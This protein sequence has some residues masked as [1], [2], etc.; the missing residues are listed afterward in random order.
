MRTKE[1]FYWIEER[2][3]IYE[4][5]K[6]GKPKPWTKDPILQQYRFCNV[7]RELDTV[8]QWIAK[9]WRTPHKT[10]RHLW[11]AMVV[12][13]LLN[14]PPTLSLVKFPVPWSAKRFVE[15]TKVA[16]AT[17]YRIFSGAYIV[18]TN[19]KAVEKIPYLV[20]Y[21]L[22]PLWK[23]RENIAAVIHNETLGTVPPPTLGLVHKVLMNYDGLGSFMAA[24]VIAD[25]KY[26]KPLVNAVDWH[27]W[28]ASGP[29]SRRGLNR[30][31]GSAPNTP[32]NEARWWAH[33]NMLHKE[34]RLLIVKKGMPDLHAQDLQ[35]CLCEFDKY[36]RTRLGEGRP[37]STY[38]GI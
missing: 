4:A 31:F 30:V 23:A 7:Y 17:N 28:A 8:T 3:K 11:F 14:W 19:G 27:T 32:W 15:L 2:H 38:P 12:A 13:R 33:L 18:S 26:V 29:G 5:R 9:H 35:N 36:E 6:A 20:E 16:Q 37:R 34:I 22:D 1:L 24:Q 21:V 10:D 25:L